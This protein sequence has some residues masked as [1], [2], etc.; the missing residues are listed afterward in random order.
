M[1]ESGFDREEEILGENR[2]LQIER[3]WEKKAN[4]RMDEG[5]GGGEL[6]AHVGVWVV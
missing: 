5:A 2:G 1:I 3:G 6:Q 4:N